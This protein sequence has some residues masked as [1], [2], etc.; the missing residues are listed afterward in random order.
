[1]T[2]IRHKAISTPGCAGHGNPKNKA[3]DSILTE[4]AEERQFVLSMACREGC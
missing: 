4:L 2:L 3:D 1:M